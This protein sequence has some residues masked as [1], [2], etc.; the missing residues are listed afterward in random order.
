MGVNNEDPEALE[1][2]VAGRPQ[3][4]PISDAGALLVRTSHHVE[5]QRKI[6]SASCHR[7]NHYEIDFPDRRRIWR[8]LVSW[9]PERRPNADHKLLPIGGLVNVD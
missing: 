2:I 3:R 1:I 9:Q 8:W 7:T 5:G 6:S 4:Q